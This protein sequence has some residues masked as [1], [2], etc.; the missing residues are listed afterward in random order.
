LK[1]DSFRKLRTSE[2]PPYSVTT[3]LSDSAVPSGSPCTEL[4]PC[5]G[6]SRKK[7]RSPWCEPSLTVPVTVEVGVALVGA[8]LVGAAVVCAAADGEAFAD[9]PDVAPEA[10]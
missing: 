10:P 9:A 6:G 5:G 7:R 3:S 4:G 1:P 2:V 8:A